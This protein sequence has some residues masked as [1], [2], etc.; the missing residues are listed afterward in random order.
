[1]QWIEM[2]T[3]ASKQDLIGMYLGTLIDS[4]FFDNLLMKTLAF[5]DLIA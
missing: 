5:L 3:C 4:C 2:N 1:M